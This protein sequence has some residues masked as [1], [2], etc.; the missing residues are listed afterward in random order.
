[1]L[2]KMTWAMV[3]ACSNVMDLMSVL[4]AAFLQD[5][6]QLLEANPR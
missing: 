2:F 6:L 1:M 5:L 3:R 4:P